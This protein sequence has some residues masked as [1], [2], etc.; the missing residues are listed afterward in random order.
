MTSVTVIETAPVKVLRRGIARNPKMF[1]RTA[2]IAIAQLHAREVSPRCPVDSRQYRE[3]VQD[4]GSLPL[5]WRVIRVARCGDRGDLRRTAMSVDS[6]ISAKSLGLT[7]TAQ[8]NL[9]LIVRAIQP[10]QV[11]QATQYR[12]AGILNRQLSD[13]EVKSGTRG[14]TRKPAQF[15]GAMF[16]VH[17]I[18]PSAVGQMLTI[19]ARD[20]APQREQKATIR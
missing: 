6:S 14:C 3:H 16:S 11:S 18:W 13:P 19:S 4:Q 17:A 12:C 10:E 9:A 1:V 7:P 15:S 8:M 20:A 5:S 2:R